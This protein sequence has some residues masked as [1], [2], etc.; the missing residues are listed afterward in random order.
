MHYRIHANAHPVHLVATVW[1]LELAEF[2]VS[3]LL[4]DYPE[5]EFT[6]TPFV[7]GDTDYLIVWEDSSFSLV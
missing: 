2:V 3:N 5:V 1:G 6:I 4:T 7:P